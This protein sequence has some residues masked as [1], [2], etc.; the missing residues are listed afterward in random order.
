MIAGLRR[1]REANEGLVACGGRE[2]VKGWRIG[3]PNPVIAGGQGYSG[4]SIWK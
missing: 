4:F 2:I 3:P 1:G